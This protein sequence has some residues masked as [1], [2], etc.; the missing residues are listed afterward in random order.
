MGKES[1][2]GGTTALLWG[3]HNQACTYSGHAVI[4]SVT[5]HSTANMCC[6][7]NTIQYTQCYYLRAESL[8]ARLIA[9]VRAGSALWDNPNVKMD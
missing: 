5:M 4:S 2:A 8:I 7:Y 9:V 6:Q 3:H 1:M